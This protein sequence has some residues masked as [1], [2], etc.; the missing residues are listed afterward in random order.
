MTGLT[1]STAYDV[2][3]AVGSV[4]I[5]LD[6]QFTAGFS[7]QPAS[8]A[9]LL[10]G[11]ILD[12]S[13][14]S[15]KTENVRCAV[16]ANGAT[17]PTAA[18]VN[19]GT[20]TGGAAVAATNGPV[21]AV[22]A[23]SSATAG[24]AKT[25]SYTGLTKNTKYD[26]YCATA[27]GVLSSKLDV[28]TRNDGFNAAP[29][30]GTYT[31]TGFTVSANVVTTG[32]TRC[33]VYA[34]NANAPSA[35]Q[36]LA[37]K[38]AGDAAAGATNGPIASTTAPAAATATA[39]TAKAFV[40]TGLTAS[41]AYDVYCAVGSV[42]IKL[43][44]QFTAGFSSQ[45][46]S[47]APLLGGTILDI[48]LTS[49]KTENVR[50]AVLANGA[51]AP[52]AAEVNAGTGTGGA[53]VGATNGPVSIVVAASSATAGSA[54]TIS[55]PQTVWNSVSGSGSGTAT[56][57]TASATADTVS[58]TWTES[59]QN[60]IRVRACTSNTDTS[61]TDN[62]NVVL[63]T[64]A[65]SSSAAAAAGGN[66]TATG[67][68]SS[69]ASTSSSKVTQVYTFASLTANAYTGN[70][71]GNI[72]CAYTCTVENAVT[73]SWCVAKTTSPYRDYKNGISITSSVARRSAKVTFVMSVA[74]SIKSLS[75]LKTL[76]A[77]NSN[78]ANFAAALTKV[79]T[80]SG[81]NITMPGTAE[82][83]AASFSSS[84]GSTLLPS[85]LALVSALWLS[86]R[87]M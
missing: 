60:N 3:C 49:R 27:S 8:A 16:L 76:V 25:I 64:P 46:A 78:A 75:E 85:M 82:V 67:S 22:V 15:R 26:I 1:A 53:A 65:S 69:A 68:A 62:A 14:T 47:A 44:D 56:V 11:T 12:I 80:A 21:V 72:E 13:L 32:S 83:A 81:L 30:I 52:T 35:T 24:T 71:K 23:A 61:Q 63:S 41:T 9:P 43:D 79:N 84:S 38:G 39:G 58:L 4:A 29:T 10:G 48:S 5:K 42:A 34:N 86:A 59:T 54:K 74:N 50:C 57:C 70:T 37:G 7:S 20:G 2:Y 51:T 66:S 28:Q 6:D 31:A 18:E 17:A 33:C 19:A 87:T 55:Q 36:I 45:P 40:M 73:C 77:A